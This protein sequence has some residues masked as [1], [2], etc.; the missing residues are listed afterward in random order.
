MKRIFLLAL[1]VLFLLSSCVSA[2]S[3]QDTPADAETNGAVQTLFLEGRRYTY[4]G[5]TSMVEIK[6][7]VFILRQAGTYR[8]SGELT[9]GRLCVAAPADGVVRLILDGLSV[10]STFGEALRI[11]SAACVVIETAAG[12]V[13]TLTD[14]RRVV[15]DGSIPASCVRAESDLVLLG[16]GSLVLSGR[17]ENAL[18]CLGGMT[19]R[20]GSLTLSAPET[21]LW[22]RD[23]LTVETGALTVTSAKRGVVASDGAYDPGTLRFLGGR[24]TAT[25][26]EAALIAP[27]AITMA[28]EPSLSA[29]ELYRCPKLET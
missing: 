1:C 2:P 17:Q 5:D 6:E 22:V 11:D 7:D 10:T 9:E 13:N 14:A 15:S 26:T 21:A 25:C 20:G 27:R 8:L 4:E 18:V 23:G 29:P 24:L 12:T 19:I 16:E 28:I 3:A